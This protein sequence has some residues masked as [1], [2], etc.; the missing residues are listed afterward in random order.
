[1]GWWQFLSSSASRWLILVFSCLAV[2]AATVVGMEALSA[3]LVTVANGLI[4][5]LGQVT[6]PFAVAVG[7]LAAAFS[8]LAVVELEDLDRQGTKPETPRH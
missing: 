2:I 5:V 6:S 1:M 3:G 8:W 7:L 4:A